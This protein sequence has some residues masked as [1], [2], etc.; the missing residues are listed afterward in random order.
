MDISMRYRGF[1]PGSFM[2]WHLESIQDR[3]YAF[4]Y[5]LPLPHVVCVFGRS[6]FVQNARLP[7]DVEPEPTREVSW[8]RRANWEPEDDGLEP[9]NGPET[10]ST[11]DKEGDSE[12]DEDTPKASTFAL[13]HE[14]QGGW[15]LELARTYGLHRKPEPVPSINN[16]EHSPSTLHHEAEDQHG[17]RAYARNSTSIFGIQTYAAI[18]TINLEPTEEHLVQINNMRALRI[19]E[20]AMQDPEDFAERN[21][22][23]ISASTWEW[24]WNFAQELNLPASEQ[25]PLDRTGP[26]SESQ[27]AFLVFLA[28]GDSSIITTS[29]GRSAYEIPESTSSTVEEVNSSPQTGGQVTVSNSHSHTATQDYSQR[30][31]ARGHPI[32][33]ESRTLARISVRAHNDVLA[34]VGACVDVGS[35]V[36]GPDDDSGT[37]AAT[38]KVDRERIEA[39]M[40]ENEL[41][42]IIS[43]FDTCLVFLAQWAFVGIK[44]KLQT[45]RLYSTMSF[46]QMWSFQ[47]NRFGFMGMF[48][49][50]VPALLTHTVLNFGGEYLLGLLEDFLVGHLTT[51]GQSRKRRKRMRMIASAMTHSAGFALFLLLAPLKVHSMLQLLSLV[52]PRPALPS[53]LSLVPF[54]ASSYI[55]LPVFP[56]RVTIEACSSWASS[57]ITS[58][59]AVLW[60]SQLTRL[61]IGSGIFHPLIRNIPK[62]DNPDVYSSRA[63]VI[64]GLDAT[65]LPGLH[66]PNAAR[67]AQPS[68]WDSIVNELRDVRSWF[69]GFVGMAPKRKMSTLERV[70]LEIEGRIAQARHRLQQERRAR[71]LSDN[72]EVQ[73]LASTQDNTNQLPSSQADR[74]SVID[75]N[76][77]SSQAEETTA[78]NHDTPTPSPSALSSSSVDPFISQPN[79]VRVSSRRGDPELVT[80]EVEINGSPPTPTAVASTLALAGTLRRQSLS[81]ETPKGQLHHVSCL[82]NYPAEMLANRLSTLTT[83]LLLLPLQGLLVRTVAWSFLSGQMGMTE[84][85]WAIRGGYFGAGIG[86][87]VKNM[88]TCFALETVVGMGLW[89]VGLLGVRALGKTVFGWG[90][91]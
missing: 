12:E 39:V 87:Y 50:N 71:P 38:S 74:V 34:T 44:F 33:P 11:L 37:L 82:S 3:A 26:L 19:L 46:R 36:K 54:S 90:K 56:T 29:Q 55:Q 59:V 14:V 40:T 7:W 80:M 10:E 64:D 67:C 41:G 1:V 85:I 48:F 53:F 86:G 25:L 61:L 88:A 76:L 30:Y 83:E 75:P 89:E 77:S 23:D 21:G 42:L 49:A 32:N 66:R 58:P 63:A 70:R 4:Q 17:P 65:M 91:L 24:D 52:P 72:S 6:F 81:A 15:S 31:D 62:P 78:T 79:S 68:G 43:T 16:P 45:F 28:G 9:L 2:A 8:V 57:V 84:G 60:V 22:P 35:D 51:K 20:V 69:L 47:R 13:E 5:R 18:G 73:T 27:L